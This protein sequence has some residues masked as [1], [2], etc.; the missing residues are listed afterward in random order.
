MPI[1][2]NDWFVYHFSHC[3]IMSTVDFL[4]YLNKQYLG[5][6]RSRSHA[7]FHNS[8]QVKVFLVCFMHKLGKLHLFYSKHQ[9]TR[10]TV[11]SNNHKLD[12]KSSSW[13]IHSVDS[14]VCRVMFYTSKSKSFQ[15]WWHSYKLS[16]K[17]RGKSSLPFP[18]SD[19]CPVVCDMVVKPWCL[20]VCLCNSRYSMHLQHYSVARGGGR[21]AFAPPPPHNTFSEFCR[22]IWEF[23]GTCKPTSMSFVPTKN[24]KYQQNIK[25]NSSFRM[26]TCEK[27][28]CS[29]A[30][31]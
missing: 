4:L 21:G 26:W 31:T 11:C 23:V 14:Q 18:F 30:Y 20:S 29:L 7:V 13:P 10:H 24:L 16:S 2:K 28:L 8:L 27:N 6:K 17:Q 19:T 12:R 25:R 15:N 5:R 9:Q 1:I 3:G 22:Y